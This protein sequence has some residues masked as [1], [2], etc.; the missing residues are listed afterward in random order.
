MGAAARGLAEK[1]FARPAL[2]DQFVRTL[3]AATL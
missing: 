1:E 2:A 3:E